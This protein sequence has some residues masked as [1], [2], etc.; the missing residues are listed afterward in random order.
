MNEHRLVLW[1]RRTEGMTLELSLYV[2][3]LFE[4]GLAAEPML[5]LA[6]T[7]EWHVE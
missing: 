6:R 2:T 4:G 1:P 3:D 5:E 7:I